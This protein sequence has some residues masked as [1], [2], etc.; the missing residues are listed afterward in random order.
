MSI[1]LQYINLNQ[2]VFAYKKSKM[3]NNNTFRKSSKMNKKMSEK[4]NTII[5]SD[6]YLSESGVQGGKA[7]GENIALISFIIGIPFLAI[8]I[9]ALCGILFGFGFSANAAVIILVLLVFVI[10]LLLT[11]GGYTIYKTKHDKKVDL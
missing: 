5:M 11:I 1:G 3:Q 4:D 2:K 8:S 10:G 9:Y 6:E 7:L